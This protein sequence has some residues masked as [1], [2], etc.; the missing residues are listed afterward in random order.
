MKAEAIRLG[1]C[2][3]CGPGRS[4]DVVGEYHEHREDDESDAWVDVDY[5]ILAC[6]GC[7]SV[8]FQEAMISSEDPELVSVMIDGRD[9][10]TLPERITHWPPPLIRPKPEWCKKPDFIHGNRNLS[11]L[12]DDVYS[13]LNADLKVPAAVA[14]RTAFDVAAEQLGI[15]PLSTFK[16]KL[17]EIRKQG[18]IGHDERD[19]LDVLVDAGNAAAH[20]GWEPNHEQLDTIVSIL[21]EFLHRTFVLNQKADG[22]RKEVPAKKRAKKSS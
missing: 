11:R 1:H 7:G 4:A 17:D 13:T 2:P 9:E 12:L 21:E 16:V 22:L 6:R 3:K 14:A 20:R 19:A 8:Y 18:R 10:L 5:R 15:D